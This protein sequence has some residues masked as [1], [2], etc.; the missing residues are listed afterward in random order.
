MLV[1]KALRRIQIS[2]NSFGTLKIPTILK[3]LV[4][5]QKTKDA[6]KEVAKDAVFVI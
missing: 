4:K 3:K 6:K 1:K 5:K 2:Y